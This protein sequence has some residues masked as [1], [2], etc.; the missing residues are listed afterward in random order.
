MESIPEKVL[1]ETDVLC[2]FGFDEEETKRSLQSW[3]TIPGKSLLFLGTEFP[4]E[5]EM[6]VSTCRTSVFQRFSYI[7]SSFLKEDRLVNMQ[8]LRDAYQ[9]IE[10]QVHLEASDYQDLG[11]Q[12]FRNLYTNLGK[13]ADRKSFTSLK[14]CLQGLPAVICGAGPSLKDRVPFLRQAAERGIVFAGGAALEALSSFSVPI[15]I[16]AGIDPNPSYE[17]C[18]MIGSFQAPFFYQSRF[19]HELLFHVQG[20]AFQVPSSSGLCLEEEL[21]DFDGGGTVTTFCTA[22]ALHLGCYPI[23]FV[24]MDL[25]YGEEQEK[26]AQ[27]PVARDSKSSAMLYE[28]V[29]TQKDWV[30]AGKWLEY[31][32]QQHESVSFYRVGTYG[33]KV[34]G[35]VDLPESKILET[36][37][38]CSQD[39]IGR[40]HLLQ[41]CAKEESCLLQK[42]EI[43]QSLQRSA[44]CVENILKLYHQ[45]YP[46]DP[47]SQGNF[48]IHIFALYEEFL[49]KHMLEPLWKIWQ[50]PM[51]RNLTDAYAKSISPWLFFQRVLK[52]YMRSVEES[53]AARTL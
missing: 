41:S 5:M 50:F 35:I 53:Y 28:G 21:F 26:Y 9:K 44:A 3:L 14:G 36:L 1:Q 32:T 31:L 18:K 34:E 12:V 29:Y 19:S 22:L 27:T 7:F 23:I 42:T 47:S 13:L 39:I 38:I 52:E 24:G 8:I 40:L 2:L 16:A 49:Y 6:F 30:I 4:F 15:H 43:E 37:S 45:S 11:V 17:R 10:W 46:E 20:P 51:E 33:L 48:I 25:A